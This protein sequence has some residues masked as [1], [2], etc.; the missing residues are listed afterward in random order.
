MKLLIV[1]Q[2]VDQNHLALGFFHDWIAGLASSFEQIEVICLFMG[3]TSLPENVRVHSLGKEEGPQPRLIYAYR[4]L[5][6]AWGLRQSY[7]AAFVHMNQE[8]ILLAG[9][10]WKVLRKRIYMWRNHY[11]GSLLTRI[12]V[13]FATK[14]FCTSKHS[15]TARFRKTLLMPVGVDT[16]HFFPDA[17][18]KRKDRSILFLARMAPSKDPLLLLKALKELRDGG[19]PF[20]ATFV[21]SP[22]P[23]DEPYYRSLMAYA[24][25]QG[26]SDSV[27]FLP[28]VPKHE[29]PDLYRAHEIFV[30]ATASGAFDKTIFEAAACGTRPLTKSKDVAEALGPQFFFD[31]TPHGLAT[32]LLALWD[33]DP[34][35]VTEVMK[36][37]VDRH[38]LA[39]LLALLAQELRA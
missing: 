17:R 5:K 10:L 37:F 39:T 11:A 1:T 34:K 28:G 36:G 7:D 2:A 8:Y 6:L 12:A 26:L 18:I 4:F 21:G 32:Q 15:Y 31:G 14:V 3:Q 35:T 33:T 25:G 38:S 9:P 16:T 23:Q 27:T 20:T 30:N 24:E 19:E 13:A 22:L 29:T